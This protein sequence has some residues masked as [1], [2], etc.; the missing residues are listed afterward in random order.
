MRIVFIMDPVSSVI[1][2][3]DTTFDIMVHAQE[4]GHSVY[5]ALLPDV[6]WSAGEVGARVRPAQM[7]RRAESPVH[8]GEWEHLALAEVDAVWI[9]KDPPFDASYLWLTQLLEH[10]RDR[11]LVLNDPRGLR[12]ANEKLYA[13][14]FAAHMPETLVSSQRDR[15]R[16]FMQQVGGQAVIK[17]I[18]GHGGAGVFVLREGDANINPI[19]EQ[20]TGHG[21][22]CAMVQRYLPEV[23]EGDKRI[24]LL[25]GEPLGAILRVPNQGEA[26]SNIHVGGQVKAT[27]LSPAEK[28]LVADVG[29]RL[30]RDGLYFVGLDVI[31]E[32]LTEVNVTSPTGI[33]QMSRLNHEALSARVIEWMERRVG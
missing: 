11:T 23:K 22:H 27:T 28:K 10:L 20:A 21:R 31:G 7:Q 15:I 5:H 29:P 16:A 14:F 25:D 18:D 24:L 30:R 12:E 1:W 8:L 3:E 4:A 2:D 17:P 33:Q 32:K 26:R 19:L 13:C 6:Y 9:R